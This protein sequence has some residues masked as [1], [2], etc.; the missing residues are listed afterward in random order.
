MISIPP[1]KTPVLDI[2]GA[3]YQR[4][5]ND[6]PLGTLLQSTEAFPGIYD[7]VFENAPF[8]YIVIGEADELPDN[9]HGAFGRSTLATL[10]VWTESRGVRDGA[11]IADRLNEIFDHCHSRGNNLVLPD[12]K[13]ISVKFE[14]LAVLKDPSDPRYRQVMINYRIDTEQNKEG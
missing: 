2:Q 11:R 9:H 13:V 5:M 3:M 7:D 12:H 10:R 6:A 8:P 4:M 1:A 14:N